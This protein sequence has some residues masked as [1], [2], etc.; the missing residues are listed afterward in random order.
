MKTK[1]QVCGR[2]LKHFELKFAEKYI[3][4]FETAASITEYEYDSVKCKIVEP[5]TV[6]ISGVETEM[7][8]KG[9]ESSNIV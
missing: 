2:D 1:P 6:N 8:K 4:Q 3:I 9:R 7:C 5:D